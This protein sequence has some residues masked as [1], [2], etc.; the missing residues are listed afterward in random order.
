MR[1]PRSYLRAIH[2]ATDYGEIIKNQSVVMPTDSRSVTYYSVCCRKDKQLLV[3]LPTFAGGMYLPA[4]STLCSS[5]PGTFIEH[6]QVKYWNTVSKRRN[7]PQQRNLICITDHNLFGSDSS[8]PLRGW[9]TCRWGRKSTQT[10][11]KTAPTVD[12]ATFW[13]ARSDDPVLL[14]PNAKDLDVKFHLRR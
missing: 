3:D 13:G 1:I 10:V 9:D 2:N 7:F 14:P 11:A 12:A 8:W 5:I 4:G 6:E